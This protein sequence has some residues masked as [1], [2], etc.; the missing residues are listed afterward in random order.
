MICV[1]IV[2]KR[3]KAADRLALLDYKTFDI[4]IEIGNLQTG[5]TR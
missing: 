5:D 4:L 2:T 3:Y 1:D